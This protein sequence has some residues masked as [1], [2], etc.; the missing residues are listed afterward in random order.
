MGYY[1]DELVVGAKERFGAYEVRRE[2]VI[3]FATRFD[4]QPFHLSDEAAARTYFGRIPAS[5]W[6]SCGMLMRM[7]VDRWRQ[8]PERQ[9]ANLGGVGVDDLRWLKPVYPGDILSCETEIV[10]KTTSRSRPEMGIVRTRITMFNQRD[11]A[12][13]S[14]IPITMV[15]TR[16]S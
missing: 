7:L 8:D 13:L 11:E 10:E 16:P 9:A 1:F 12:V 5:G 6:H 15:R 4:P 3:D 2:D 14:M